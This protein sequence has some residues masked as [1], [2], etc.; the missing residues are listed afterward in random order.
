VLLTDLGAVL[1]G[2][3]R[4]VRTAAHTLKRSVTY[5]APEVLRLERPD[6]RA[7]LFSLGLILV[8]M[9]GRASGSPGARAAASRGPTSAERGSG[10]ALRLGGADEG[11]ATRVPGQRAPGLWARTAAGGDAQAA[12]HAAG[13]SSSRGVEPSAAAL[14]VP[15]RPPHAAL[16]LQWG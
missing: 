14:C 15:A 8:E 9:A 4:R 3:S 16:S 2:T 1:T 5:A 7:D 6:A 13:W 11:R 12:G 10:S